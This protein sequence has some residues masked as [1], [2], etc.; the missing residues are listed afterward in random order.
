VWVSLVGNG[1]HP[2][3]C[4][5]PK[6]SYCGAQQCTHKQ[7]S[8][9]NPYLVA[10][11]VR[12]CGFFSSANVTAFGPAGMSAPSS[13]TGLRQASLDSV[14]TRPVSWNF[15]STS[16]E[17]LGWSAHNANISRS[18][19]KLV[20]QVT[21]PAVAEPWLESP[22]TWMNPFD[23]PLVE[24]TMWVDQ[25]GVHVCVAWVT[26]ADPLWNEECTTQ[27]A[28]KTGKCVCS[29]RAEVPTEHTASAVRV[30]LRDSSE[31]GGI[32][33]AFRLVLDAPTPF[34]VSLAALE[35]VATREGSDR[36]YARE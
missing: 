31:W 18:A 16:S 3:C 25:P 33:T 12:R 17:L 28:T 21:A 24:L 2:Q 30:D 23:T 6:E 1:Q 11:G 29:L 27:A 14:I 10:S 5:N 9:N 4:S 34:N 19:G 26:E 15:S 20:G 36:I 35:T 7:I 22:L 32:I 8:W 13:V